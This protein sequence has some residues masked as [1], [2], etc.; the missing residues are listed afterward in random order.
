MYK[1][2]NGFEEHCFEMFTRNV[3]NMKIVMERLGN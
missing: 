1:H 2:Q 3:V